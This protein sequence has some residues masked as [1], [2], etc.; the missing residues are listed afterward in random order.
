MNYIKPLLKISKLRNWLNFIPFDFFGL[1][2]V[3]KRGRKIKKVTSR[4]VIIFLILDYNSNLYSVSKCQQELEA[5]KK[6]I[7]Q[8]IASSC[9]P[10]F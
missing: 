8:N 4:A 10:S 3:L 2:L 7:A 1:P 5:V 9:H 6:L